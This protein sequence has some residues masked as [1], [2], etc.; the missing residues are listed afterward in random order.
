M[1]HFV[2]EP[3][4]ELAQFVNGDRGKNYPSKSD[5]VDT[6]IPFINAGHLKSGEVDFSEM[7]Y[8][9]ADKFRKLGS[10]KTQNNDLLYCLRGS[11]GKTAIVNYTDNSAIASSLVIRRSLTMSRA[12]LTAANPVRLPLRV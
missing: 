8:I 4:G 1:S 9:H 5:F 11:L 10:G 2:L 6:G 7:N 12:I 3:L